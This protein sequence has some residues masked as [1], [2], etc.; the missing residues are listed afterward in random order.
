MRLK[1]VV[2]RRA[3]ADVAE[4]L[5]D[6]VRVF[7]VPGLAKTRASPYRKRRFIC[8]VYSKKFFIKG[9]VFANPVP[10]VSIALFN[11]SSRCFFVYLDKS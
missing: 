5:F 3:R 6:R 8:F 11:N 10:Y 7:A 4:P 1:H 9:S 2:Q